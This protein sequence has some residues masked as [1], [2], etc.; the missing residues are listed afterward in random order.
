MWPPLPIQR[1]LAYRHSNRWSLSLTFQRSQKASLKRDLS[2]LIS[3]AR[4]RRYT[5]R[6][7]ITGTSKS[8]PWPI[9]RFHRPLGR[10]RGKVANRGTYRRREGR[11][12]HKLATNRGTKPMVAS[13]RVPWYSDPPPAKSLRSKSTTAS[14]NQTSCTL[15]LRNSCFLMTSASEWTTRNN[16]SKCRKT[17]VMNW[18]VWCQEWISVRLSNWSQPTSRSSGS[19]ASTTRRLR[20]KTTCSTLFLTS[21]VEIAI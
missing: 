17:I 16:S 10:I 21:V 3:I 20:D 11:A 9:W 13:P 6:S 14:Q 4:A 2:R 8:S 18:T 19:K 15:N 7:R 1:R 5:R 12:R